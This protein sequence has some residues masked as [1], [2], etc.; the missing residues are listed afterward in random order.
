MR[1]SVLPNS[2]TPVYRQIYEQLAAQILSGTLTPGTAL[3]PIRT[4]AKEIGVSVITV[5]GA[6]DALEA[7][8]LIETRAGSGCYVAAFAEDERL[9]RRTDALKEPLSA[10]LAT[11]KTY[12]FSEQELHESIRLA[13]EGKTN[14]INLIEER[15]CC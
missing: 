3:P 7:D 5:R 6:W 15:P 14:H 2:E 12:G 4:V 11:A 10:L 1:L 9:R 13:W 8:G